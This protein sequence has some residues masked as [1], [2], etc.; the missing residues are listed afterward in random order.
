MIGSSKNE[1]AKERCESNQQN[2][3]QD[4]KSLEM[5][6]WALLKPRLD[7]WSKHGI[8]SHQGMWDGDGDEWSGGLVGGLVPASDVGTRLTGCWEMKAYGSLGRKGVTGNNGL[9]VC[10]GQRIWVGSGAENK[11]DTKMHI[12]RVRWFRLGHL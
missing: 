4:R 11:T 3:E 6:G 10:I 8:R 2:F 12:S 1:N 5:I 9:S 7:R